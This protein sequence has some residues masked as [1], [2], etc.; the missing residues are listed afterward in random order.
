MTFNTPKV[1]QKS[2]EHWL[3]LLL[4]EHQIP[5]KDQDMSAATTATGSETK[6]DILR[7]KGII[8][9]TGKPDGTKVVIQGVQE[10]YDVK[11][12]VTQSGQED[13][14]LNGGKV[15]FIGR[16]LEDRKRLLASCLQF[17]GLGAGDVTIH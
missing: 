12:V 14:V 16:G 5:D 11:E 3:Q 6:L 1:D 9:P 7:V 13:P 15:V 4:W 2:F 10:L 17:M 8:R